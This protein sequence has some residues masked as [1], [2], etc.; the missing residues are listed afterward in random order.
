MGTVLPTIFLMIAAFILNVVLHRQVNAQR[1]EIA[2]L[3]APGYDDR[4]IAVHYLKLTTAVVA[5][6]VVL[7][8]VLG[9]WASPAGRSVSR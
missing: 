9:Y 1:T 5:G 8:L 6:G 4:A 3:K 7:G 2:A